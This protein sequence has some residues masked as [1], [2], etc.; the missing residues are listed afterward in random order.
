MWGA[1]AVTSMSEPWSL[2][3][4]SVRLGAMP[5]AQWVSKDRQASP[6]RWM[7]CRGGVGDDGLVDVGLEV[8]RGTAEGDG[9]VVGDDADADHGEGFALGGVDLAGRASCRVRPRGW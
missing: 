9:V 7:D 6:R 4:I 1:R 8:A 3:S 5:R 2:R